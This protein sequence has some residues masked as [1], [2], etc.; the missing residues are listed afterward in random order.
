MIQ[1]CPMND[2]H[3][4]TVEQSATYDT[5]GYT[6][7]RSRRPDPRFTDALV[8]ALMVDPGA[9]VADVGAGTGN[10]AAELTAL[11]YSVV[12]V[13]PS[14]VMRAQRAPQLPVE[15]IAAV[16]ERI[17]LR[18]GAVDAAMCV[19][20]SHHFSAMEQALNEL[21]RVTRGAIV[22]LTFDPR[23]S[24][25]FWFQEYFASVWR[26]SFAVFPPIAQVVA[27]V[28]AQT[29]RQVETRPLPL[30]W[31]TCDLVAA[32]GWRRPEI[33]LDTT[34]RAGMSA[35]AQ[36]DQSEVER[37]LKTL[38]HDMLSGAWQRDN[39]TLLAQDDLDAG[40]HLVVATT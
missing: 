26:T 9:L 39:S 25:P 31:D 40:Y 7:A 3:A 27:V 12:A 28:A 14:R 19:L 29:G 30:P 35:F 34:V 13:E 2:R 24:A 32:A 36:A 20:S 21:A 6:Y 23:A 22:L 37:G 10:Y 38:E 8:D 15:W 5:I 4:A 1:S 11:G 18:D 33:Y 17:P 16:A